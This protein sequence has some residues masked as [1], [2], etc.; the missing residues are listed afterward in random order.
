M[1]V[2]AV[3]LS[4]LSVALDE[5]VTDWLVLNWGWAFTGGAEGASSV[6]GAVAGSMITLAGVVFSMTLVALSLAS[7]QL[8]PRLLRNFMRDT[9][10]QVVLGTFVSAFL[11]CLLVLRTIRRA[12]ESAFV[13]HLSV[14]LGVLFAVVSV[15]VL[16]YFIHHVSVSIQV[17]EIVARVGTE[18]IEGLDRLFPEHIG[19]GAPQIPNEPPDVEFL[20]AFDREARP[21][22]SDGDGYIQFIDGE[23]LMAL[24]VKEDIVIRLERSP[25]HYVIAGS[26]LVLVWPGTRIVDQLSDRIN[27]AFVLGNQRTAG[28]DLE[29][30]VNQL[31]EVAV[32]ALSPGLNDP[33]TAITCVDQLGS[34]LC[35]L[36]T[37]EWPSPY[38][39]DEQNQLRVIARIDPFS[40]ITDT[41]F[42]QIRQYGGSSAAVMIRLLDTITV[43]AEFTHRPEDRA[44]LLRHADMIARGA[45]D[46][47]S[48]AEDRRAV[49]ERYQTTMRLCSESE[50]H[51]L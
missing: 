37:R 21:V 28:Q 4:F 48:E 46:G 45:R 33:F 14:T 32:R 35:R 34:A 47:L 19:R 36:A 1:A 10:T 16:I 23:T 18:L 6:L 24:A 27:A 38:R 49:E 7:S 5:R 31:V 3:A 41:A 11:Y 29:F 51:G 8:G 22:N 17:N 20:D 26:P 44:A 50:G 2:G 13:P 12:E 15:G 43:I 30:A 40:A 39:H 25:G 42:N 9:A